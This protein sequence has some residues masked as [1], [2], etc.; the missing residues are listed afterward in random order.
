M[1]AFKKKINSC[2][3]GDRSALV[4]LLAQCSA[5][6]QYAHY[7][8][9]KE[10]ISRNPEKPFASSKNTPCGQSGCVVLL[11]KLPKDCT[12]ATIRQWSDTIAP[13]C[14][15]QPIKE[16]PGESIRSALVGTCLG[17]LVL[18][19][20]YNNNFSLPTSLPDRQ[21]RQVSAGKCRGWPN[22]LYL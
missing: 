18:S 8:A 16:G 11:S 15:I 14:S 21:T 4:V 20:I 12:M 7:D 3:E 9:D 19:I 1:L 5:E 6:L 10:L 22:S 17:D 13:N 2:V